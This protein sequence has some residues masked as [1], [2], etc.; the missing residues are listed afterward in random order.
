MCLT[1]PCTL[2]LIICGFLNDSYDDHPLLLDR[3]ARLQR[4]PDNDMDLVFLGSAS[5]VPSVTR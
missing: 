3:T 4:I 1:V 2:C 5:C